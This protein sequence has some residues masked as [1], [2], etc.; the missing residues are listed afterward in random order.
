MSKVMATFVNVEDTGEAVLTAF[1]DFG[2][3]ISTSKSLFPIIDKLKWSICP[4]SIKVCSSNHEIV[5]DTILDVC[6]SQDLS[7][8]YHK[9]KFIM[10][11]SF[12][13]ENIVAV[14][15]DDTVVKNISNKQFHDW[16]ISNQ[17]FTIYFPSAEIFDYA[18]WG[19]FL[20][21]GFSDCC[22]VEDD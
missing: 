22:I 5:H 21:F 6:S 14:F 11:E 10:T 2:N 9:T 12:S 1:S 20:L 18:I 19:T 3:T 13:Y 8:C 4:I 15:N 7:F 16:T 17:E